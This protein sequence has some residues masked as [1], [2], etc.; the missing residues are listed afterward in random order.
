MID[1]NSVIKRYPPLTSLLQFRKYFEISTFMIRNP[2]IEGGFQFFFGS[3][4]AESIREKHSTYFDLDPWKMKLLQWKNKDHKMK[5]LDFVLEISK[6]TALKTPYAC[7]KVRKA[8]TN[9]REKQFRP[10]KKPKTLKRILSRN[11]FFHA[12]KKLED[13]W[14]YHPCCRRCPGS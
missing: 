13:S 3:W 1:I 14:S 8:E 10:R 4:K 5:I 7:E 6:I 12:K 9:W 11:F 2:W